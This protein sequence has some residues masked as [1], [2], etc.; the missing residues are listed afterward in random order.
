MKVTK[1]K[2]EDKFKV[3]FIFSWPYISKRFQEA[4]SNLKLETFKL[5]HSS[6]LKADLEAQREVRRL[7][8]KSV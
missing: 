6:K 8:L 4:A 1:K 2:L 5:E 3:G 7:S